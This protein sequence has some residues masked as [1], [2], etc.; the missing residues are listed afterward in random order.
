MNR[1]IRFIENMVCILLGMW[2]YRVF[3][4]GTP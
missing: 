1:L 3:T 2:L 4:Q